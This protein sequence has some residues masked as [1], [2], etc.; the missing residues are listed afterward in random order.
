MAWFATELALFAASDASQDRLELLRRAADPVAWQVVLF[1]LL[2]LALLPVT[3]AL[4]LTATG[5]GWWAIGGASFV[6]LGARVGEGALRQG[7]PARAVL[8]VAG[9]LVLLAG[10][11]FVLARVARLLPAPLRAAW[12]LAVWSGWT[13]LFVGFLRRAGPALGNGKTG[14]TGWLEFVH[15]DELRIAAALCAFVLLVGAGLRWLLDGR[16]RFAR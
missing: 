14:L 3:R 13:L 5:V 12:P 4:T 6:F 9:V 1:A 10:V 15:G 16:A 8:A 11:L 7:G 2:G